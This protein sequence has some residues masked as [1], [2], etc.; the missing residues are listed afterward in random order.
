M[1]WRRRAIKSRS[2]LNNSGPTG[3]RIIIKLIN[4]TRQGGE[5]RS[6]TTITPPSAQICKMVGGDIMSFRLDF[7]RQEE[8]KKEKKKEE[9]KNVEV[10]NY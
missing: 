3:R 2:A 8:K 7:A 6:N 10:D 1:R 4:F 9:W 5:I